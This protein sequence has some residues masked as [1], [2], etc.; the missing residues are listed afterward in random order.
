MHRFSTPEKSIESIS[1]V[2]LEKN[3]NINTVTPIRISREV[4]PKLSKKQKYFS[5]FVCKSWQYNR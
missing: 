4:I 5:Y 3:L 2:F 1:N